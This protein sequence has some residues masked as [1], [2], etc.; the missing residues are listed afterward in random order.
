MFKGLV[1]DSDPATVV[2]KVSVALV[3][4]QPTDASLLAA[5]TAAREALAGR[6]LGIQAGR[7]FTRLAQPHRKTLS[8]LRTA[9]GLTSGQFTDFVRVLDLSACGADNRALQ[10]LTLHQEAATLLVGPTRPGV[11]GLI[12]LMRQQ[13]LPGTADTPGL[14]RADIIVALGASG[15]QSL[16][17]YPAHVSKPTRLV[18]T[19][20]PGALASALTGASTGRLLAHGGPG[21]GKTTVL[22]ALEEALSPGSIVVVYDCYA[23]GRYLNP[24]NDRHSERAVVQI[25]NETAVRGGVLPVVVP[26]GPVVH[27]ELWRGLER[28]LTAVA[29][30]LP[31]G[32]LLVV[33][34]DAADNAV[35]AADQVGAPAFV[36]GL[37]HLQLPGNVRVL[38]TAR[39]ARRADVL[40][41]T[42]Q[43]GIAQ[44]T[45]PAFDAA[46]S[47]VMLRSV[48]PE[49][50]DGHCAAF[51]EASKGVARVQAYA[52]GVAEQ[53]QATDTSSEPD[54][55]N[56]EGVI[57][58]ADAGLTAI[59]DEVLASALST[60][61]DRAVRQHHMAILAAMA[62]PARPLTLAR[63]LSVSEGQVRQLCEDMFP[64]LRI[65]ENVI[66]FADE[67]FEHH[68]RDQLSESDLRQA[69][70]QFAQ[71]FL[72]RRNVDEEAARLVGQHLFNAGR[73][74]ELLELALEDGAPEA[75][76]DGMARAR[77]LRARLT[78]AL[79]AVA[80]RG[81]E[82]LSGE[83]VRLL[84]A[85]GDAARTDSS[86]VDTI[87]ERPELAVL[88]ADAATVAEVLL[89][90]ESGAWRGRAHLRAA[91][92]LAWAGERAT[93]A[94]EQLD[95]ACAWLRAWSRADDRR[96]GEFGPEDVAYGVHAAYV[97]GGLDRAHRLAAGWRPAK[98]VDEV[99][100]H[101]ARYAPSHLPVTQCIR[102]LADVRASAWV[103]AQFAVTYAR[104]GQRLPT[105]WVQ[106]IAARL[107]RM[108]RRPVPRP[109]EWGVSFCEVA[110]GHGA[111]K[112]RV[113]RLLTRFAPPI[114]SHVD[115][116]TGSR[117]MLAPLRAA[118]LDAALSG[119]SLTNEDLLP[120]Q[121]RPPAD[122]PAGSYDKNESERRQFLE[123]AGRLLPVMTARAECVVT[124]AKRR[125]GTDTVEAA[126]TVVQVV[127]STLEG[128]GGETADRFYRAGDRHR[129]WFVAAVEALASAVQAVTEDSSG[130]G[131]AAGAAVD[132]MRTQVEDTLTNVGDSIGRLLADGAA[133]A[134][135]RMGRTLLESSVAEDV[136]L[137]LLQR[138]GD[139]MET[140]AFP[141]T[142][143]R[144]VLLDAA[145]AAQP[146]D[147]DLAGDLFAAAV[148]AASGVD[149]DIALRLRALLTIADG[150]PDSPADG[151]PDE[152]RARIARLLGH[153]VEDA[154]PFV[155]DPQEHLPHRLA[156][157]VA[158]RL[159]GPTGL[160]LACR[161]ED[162]GHVD[163]SDGIRTVV[164]LLAAT[165]SLDAIDAFWMLRL[166]DQYADPVSPAVAIL[167]SLL[168]RVPAGRDQAIVCLGALADWVIRD[169]TPRRQADVA[170]RLVAAAQ[171]WGLGQIECVQKLQA[172]VRGL[173][174]LEQ[175]EQ[176][177][178]TSRRWG[179]LGEGRQVDV[180]AL[181]ADAS[182]ASAEQ[183]LRTLA[184]AYV[185][186]EEVVTYLTSAARRAGPAG[187][188]D[189]LEALLQLADRRLRDARATRVAAAVA[190]MCNEWRASMSVWNWARKRLPEW[191]TRHLLNLFTTGMDRH[192]T[193]P[194]KL[195]QLPSGD[196]VRSQWL[197][198]AAASHL[199]EL[200]AAQLY[201]LATTLAETLPTASV[202]THV[203]DWALKSPP[204]FPPLAGA[205]NPSAAITIS[206][207]VD[208]M[209]ARQAL[210]TPPSEPAALL[211][212]ALWALLG[213][214][215]R[216]VRW[217]AAHTVRLLL[218]HG[219]DGR[220]VA[221]ALWR[222]AQGSADG[223]ASRCFRS[224]TLEFF[225]LSARHW[226]LIA[227][228]RVA[229]DRPTVLAPLAAELAA[230]A[231]DRSQPHAAIREL[232]RQVAMDVATSEHEALPASALNDLAFTNRPKACSTSK[233]P[234]QVGSRFADYNTRFHF[235][236]MDVVPYWFIPLAEV[237]HGV[238][239]AD[240]MTRAD[241]W[242]TDRW[243]RSR[244]ETW[245]DPRAHQH[246]RSWGLISADHG[247]LPIV[248]TLGKYLEYHA[249][250]MV[251]GE[252]IDENTLVHR[253]WTETSDPWEDWLADHLPRSRTHWL[254]DARSPLPAIALTLGAWGKLQ[255]SDVL[256][257]GPVSE[258]ETTSNSTEAPE[259]TSR[260]RFDGAAVARQACRAL[261]ELD[262]NPGM[263][264]VSASITTRADRH[265]CNA[266]LISAL[267]TPDASN[268][269]LAA[270]A[271][272]PR[273][274]NLPTAGD[275]P[276]WGDELDEPELKLLGWLTDDQSA[277]EGLDRDDPLTGG[278]SG[279][280][281]FPFAAFLKWARLSSDVTGTRFIDPEGKVGAQVTLWGDENKR[282]QRDGD[283]DYSGSCLTVSRSLLM[284]YLGQ[285]GL[286]LI[287][288]TDA[289]VYNTGRSS[290]Q[291][292]K[293]DQRRARYVARHADG[294]VDSVEVDR[295]L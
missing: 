231:A 67:D 191:V 243:G 283:E 103:Q 98:F 68:I 212:A 4:N 13:M 105:R 23:N 286:S 149:A 88:H 150:I 280:W 226:L 214:P 121:L 199:D 83:A 233:E 223:D 107:D 164:P 120:E 30:G 79:R 236:S 75:I 12:E 70:D 99:T 143:R 44:V 127:C 22:T 117:Q 215:D 204:S 60:V 227:F 90:E 147:A 32:A 48:F 219:C 6:P 154:E 106:G 153:A 174:V 101:V 184:E 273:P 69:H 113:R 9:S 37:W 132:S 131:A 294:R 93:E 10:V 43:L 282:G 19:T 198:P 40:V 49:A 130:R 161:W 163:L 285:R 245:Q 185:S 182:L 249:L 208:A 72:A 292:E 211:S 263:I 7:A 175:D 39:S 222:C 97:L 241:A 57:E 237:F 38:M 46:A 152:D 3:S 176:D 209:A 178:Q 203:V 206:S 246:E 160:A 80:G 141:A 254:A 276:P 14:R 52:L 94:A 225:P 183:D 210:P 35:Y 167:K 116:Y 269:L 238:D 259:R 295:T 95:L 171:E 78:L 257:T 186:D 136:A 64:A 242:I 82:D 271:S 188:V 200:T 262:D 118:C 86:L 247:S 56:L 135:V 256:E 155:P 123:I 45:L 50:L 41:G 138:A 42:E 177:T 137:Q 85:A 255:E 71:H 151:P 205:I 100:W 165:G 125:S 169:L 260:S 91:A 272:S 194:T 133:Y 74:R 61:H 181:I 252:L 111:S 89:R 77:A 189:A 166:L 217:R 15:E 84:L 126:A 122:H 134:W 87:R 162:D 201:T 179:S 81:E 146:V 168:G 58:R 251:A 291:E 51:H 270:L 229:S 213:H 193:Y 218:T 290:I 156:L 11:V 278:I 279:S 258:P 287:S 202:K 63:V 232:A 29:D 114:P 16:F 224:A 221:A 240:I 62:R 172:R 157:A 293:D 170:R 148:R 21:V 18:P 104:T 66:G 173:A 253:H 129:S 190:E 124:A 142:E 24:A 54:E 192:R 235:D 234:R 76:T 250:Q 265:A 145:S 92:L 2:S 47:A 220:A 96:R 264:V 34:V 53:P 261:E 281:R 26:D 197:L 274:L 244:E 25:A 288:A 207:P 65:S 140:V 144:D 128:F 266:W 158:T 248:E 289:H 55:P 284:A 109:A 195:L 5:L 31:E 268:A 196:P 115:E 228:A 239:L 275:R 119:R 112:S 187:R 1:E 59:F 73:S 28:T 159:D 110:L 102:D 277:R 180:A 27:S 33:A 20:Q 108:P 267:S 139:A 36:R 216:R 17:P 230:A 8:T